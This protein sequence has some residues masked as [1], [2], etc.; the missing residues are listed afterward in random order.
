MELIRLQDA[1]SKRAYELYGTY[2]KDENGYVNPV[3]GYSYEEFLEYVEKKRHWTEGEEL[4]EGFVADTTYI[5]VDDNGDYTGSFNFRHYLN[6]FLREGPG[7]VGYGISKVY[8]GRGY[9]TKGL[10][11][12]IEII[13]EHGIDTPEIYLEVNKDNP[14]S[15]KVQLANGA[16]IHHESDKCLYTRIAL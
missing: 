3:Y 8:R 14:A 13:R 7:H 9:A 11:M 4:P 2:Q 6:D 1:D 12:L 16:Y 5:L 10:A 15:Q